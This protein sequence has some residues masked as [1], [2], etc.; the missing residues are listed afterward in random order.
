MCIRDRARVPLLDHR[1]VEFAFSI[2]NE[3]KI[4]GSW[5]KQV[6]RESMRGILPESIRARKNKMGYPTPF[7]SWL[8]MP[9]NVEWLRDV[10]ASQQFNER[11]F[12][13]RDFVENLITEHVEQ[14][15]DHSWQLCRMISFEVFCQKFLDQPF[16]AKPQNRRPNRPAANIART[17]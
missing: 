3:L 5:T 4:D 2:P 12:V 17:N 16:V 7:A 13:S 15:R 11:N 9:E 10:L 1:I 14:K 8:R 6:I